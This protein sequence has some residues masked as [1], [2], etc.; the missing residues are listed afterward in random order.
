MGRRKDVTIRI[1][2]AI[3]FTVPAVHM[4]VGVLKRFLER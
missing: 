3:F 4:L 1:T 2:L